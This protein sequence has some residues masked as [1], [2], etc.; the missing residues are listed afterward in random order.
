MLNHIH[1]EVKV[2]GKKTHSNGKKTTAK[3]ASE[4]RYKTGAYIKQQD[5]FVNSKIFFPSSEIENELIRQAQEK[6]PDKKINSH[7]FELSKHI[8]E[9][10]DAI[11]KRKDAQL[12]REVIV[13]LYEELPLEKQ[14]SILKEFI[15]ENFTSK[16]MIADVCIH[17]NKDQKNPHAHIMLTMR[18]FDLEKKSFGKK[19]RDWND[20]KQVEKY[21]AHWA[22]LSESVLK[23]KI[24]HRSFK[25]LAEEATDQPLQALYEKADRLK[26]QNLTWREI[27]QNKKNSE[28]AKINE[29]NRDERN[30]VKTQISFF[31]SVFG[32]IESKSNEFKEKIYESI[33]EFKSRIKRYGDRMDRAL[34]KP[35]RAN[36]TM[37]YRQ[38]LQKFSKPNDRFSR[39]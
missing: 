38:R 14:V 17:R 5:Q 21:R 31:N 7:S 22:E 3:S 25:R 4:Y 29:L 33:N 27:V 10:T 23:R 18:D 15:Q 26:H 1:L 16:G 19:N 2:T 6:Y 11:E 35:I 20:Q 32:M 28:K 12:F 30:Q 13:S 39:T 9:T 37:A 24:E 34:T 36:P 8:W